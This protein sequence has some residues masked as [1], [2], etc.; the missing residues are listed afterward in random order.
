MATFIYAI[1]GVAVMTGKPAKQTI[2][3]SVENSEYAFLE[4]P[5]DTSIRVLKQGDAFAARTNY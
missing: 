2:G 3:I 1:G 4:I 5:D